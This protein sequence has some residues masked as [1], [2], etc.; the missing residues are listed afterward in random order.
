MAP[1]T[2]LLASLL[3]AAGVCAQEE[4]PSRY[5]IQLPEG[6]RQMT[7]GEVRTLRSKLPP[8]L[9]EMVKPDVLD[10]FGPVERWLKEGFD[11]RAL[12][13]GQQ[14][15]EP[16]LDEEGLAAI[17][18]RVEERGT[19]VS[20]K[21]TKVGLKDHPALEVVRQISSMQALEIYAPTGGALI[22][23]QFRANVDDFNAALPQFRRAIATLEFAREPKGPAKLSDR[24]QNAAIVGAIVGLVLL[25]LYKWSRK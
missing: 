22:V 9:R 10:R 21:L 13:V 19:Y 12:T 7:P 17:R 14:E 11:G 18:S 3:L 24:L 25:V 23:F 20:G 5:R 8:D 1:L 4:R 15:G 6:W 16:A 2:V